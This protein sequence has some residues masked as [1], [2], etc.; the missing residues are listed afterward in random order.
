LVSYNEMLISAT[1][2][3]SIDIITY[4]FNNKDDKLTLGDVQH[5]IGHCT[6]HGTNKNT[7]ELLE[8][9]KIKKE[10]GDLTL[11][12]LYKMIMELKNST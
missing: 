3:N 4:L 9:F 12:K 1:A 6:D 8:K 7:L 2:G 11:E 5:A 10:V